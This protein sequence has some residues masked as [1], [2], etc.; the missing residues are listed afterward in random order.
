MY[1]NDNT[2]DLLMSEIK[3]EKTQTNNSNNKTPNFHFFF[4][5]INI[6]V[7]HLVRRYNPK[8]EARWTNR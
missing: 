6:L 7:V 8:Y 1:I 5:P 4:K 2:I 3:K